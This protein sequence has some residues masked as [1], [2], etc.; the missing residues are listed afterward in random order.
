MKQIFTKFVW[1]Q[2]KP[3]IKWSTLISLKTDGGAGLINLKRKEEAIKLSWIKKIKTNLEFQE[4]TD[5]ALD[6][7]IGSLIWEAN[8]KVQDVERHIEIDSFW[9]D[10]MIVWSR[11]YSREPSSLEEVRDQ[12]LWYNSYIKIDKEIVFHQLLSEVGIYRI[13]DILH[14]NNEFRTLNEIEEQTHSKVP[15][16]FYWGLIAAIPKA[17]KDILKGNG[18]EDPNVEGLAISQI[19]ESKKSVALLYREI[20]ANQ[21]VIEEYV[22]RW[23]KVGVSLDNDD[24]LRAFLRINK[25]S[26]VVKLR[27]FQYRMLVGAITMNTH[28]YYYG[29]KDSKSC[30]FCD[31][32]EETLNHL[33]YQCNKRKSLIEWLEQTSSDHVTFK[34]VLL[35]QLGNNRLNTFSLFMKYHIYSYRC[36]GKTP[37]VFTLKEML[38][39]NRKIEYRIAVGKD[40]VD[41]HF[42]KWKGIEI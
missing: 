11:Y 31:G 24:L 27:S 1:G 41:T 40:Q 39:E 42:K 25:L 32:E 3:K 35:S 10:V 23:H 38:K 29:I 4:L 28:L 34:N 17:W 30:S 20:N 36:Q 2:K 8:M 26:N 12:I 6:S 22:N 19:V 9:R 5:Q 37:T 16:T 18:L 13:A 15:F 33:F 21:K 7:K 14:P